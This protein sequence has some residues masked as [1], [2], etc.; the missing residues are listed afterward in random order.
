MQIRGDRKAMSEADPSVAPARAPATEAVSAISEA[1][2][3]RFLLRAQFSALP[4]EVEAVR[5]QG[6]RAWLDARFAEP[7]G[8]APAAWL[9][10][11]GHN[12][13]SED[14]HY[15]WPQGGDFMIWNQLIAQPDQCRQRLA[16]ALSQYFVISLN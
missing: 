7:R 1:A 10:A 6:Y 12:R 4:E 3:A 11:H 15:F 14:R 2:A 13:V 5:A 16:F 8:D 9:D